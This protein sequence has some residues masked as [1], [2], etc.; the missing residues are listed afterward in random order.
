[1]GVPLFNHLFFG[2]Y[3]D[4]N[5]RYKDLKLPLGMEMEDEFDFFE[6]DFE[7]CLKQLCQDNDVS[8]AIMGKK[9]EGYIVIGKLVQ[10]GGLGHTWKPTFVEEL[11]NA[12]EKDVQHVASVKKVFEKFFGRKL[13]EPKHMLVHYVRG[14]N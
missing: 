1:M 4:Y 5:F 2:Y 12:S 10:Q 13:E 11:G 8:Y 3:T 9:D 14:Y 7:F 6:E